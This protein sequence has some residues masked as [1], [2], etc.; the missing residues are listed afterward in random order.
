[1]AGKYPFYL[2]ADSEEGKRNDM[3]VGGVFANEVKQSPSAPE[4]EIAS[5]TVG[6]LAK[7]NDVRKG[8]VWKRV[9]HVTLKSIANNDEI[10]AIHTKWQEKLEP[11]KAEINKLAG[12]EWEE[13]EIPRLTTPPTPPAIAGGEKLLEEW[14]NLRR[15]RQKEI[16]ASIALHANTE[17]LYDQP[18]VDK[19]RVRVSGPFTMES[20]SPHRYLGLQ[21]RREFEKSLLPHKFHVSGSDEIEEDW[22]RQL[23]P[24]GPGEF[25]TI[26]LDNLR[27][28]GAQTG[29][30]GERLSFNTLD[31][32]PGQYLHGAG[33]FTD[34]T[35]NISRVAVCV[36]PEYGTV[37]E[38]LIRE[39]AREAVKGIGFD[40]LL[41]TGFNFD[42]MAGEVT[43][44]FGRL[45]VLLSKMAPELGMGD[46]LLKKTGAGNLFMIFGEPDIEIRHVD[47][48]QLQVEIHGLDVYDPTTGL[49]R[50]SSTDD[51]ACWFIDT[52]Y[53]GDSFFVRHAYFTGADKPYKRL[54]KTLKADIDESAWQSLYRTVS[55]PFPKPD[56]GKIA[57][58]VI[59]HYGDEVLKVYELKG[60]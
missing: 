9:P 38:D 18:Y 10:D 41:I 57:I 35:G 28:T 1:M 23:I 59:N 3:E 55:R 17:T 54:S 45:T 2:L 51:I 14:W 16:D 13:W 27:K 15:T 29:F 6:G 52:D 36:G 12:K 50:S 19:K 5:P 33:E 30:K 39:A 4:G 32:F 7:T 34:K 60:E 44:H 22:N 53:N 26:I 43:K 11:L 20:L 48:G 58:K 24:R 40:I 46:E 56:S 8:F 21:G 42:G 47:D 49:V 31:S 25:E 37:S